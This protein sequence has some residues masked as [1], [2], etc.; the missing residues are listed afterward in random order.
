MTRP[1]LNDPSGNE[2][3]KSLTWCHAWKDSFDCSYSFFANGCSCGEGETSES[4]MD[5]ILTA[6]CE[7]CPDRNSNRAQLSQHAFG[8]GR[9]G[10]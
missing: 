4:Q 10:R 9:R 5:E 1:V 7:L 2:H 6:S 3:N 8:S